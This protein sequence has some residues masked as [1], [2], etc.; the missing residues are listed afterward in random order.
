MA[1][2]IFA[3]LTSLLAVLSLGTVAT[4]TAEDESDARSV[5]EAFHGELMAVMQTADQTST[6]DRNATL[7]PV[8]S[9]TFDTAYMAQVASGR[10]WKDFSSDQQTELI[11]IF[12]AFTAA[13]YAN[14]FDGFNGERFET[15]AERET[16]GRK[17]LQTQIV[18]SDGETVPLTYLVHDRQGEPQIADVFLDG[19]VSELATRRS[20]FQSVLK[21]GGWQ[22]LIDSLAAKTQELLNG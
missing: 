15:L 13:N 17:V 7:T 14:R 8:I 10:H 16:R 22:S 20:E 11:T 1:L 3:F 19:S 2:R 18:K 9:A 21:A 6:A 5:V 4:A 12:T